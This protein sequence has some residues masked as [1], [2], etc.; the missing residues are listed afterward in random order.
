MTNL[1]LEIHFKQL[2]AEYRFSQLADEVSELINTT[3]WNKE[4]LDWRM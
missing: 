2:L 4:N 3:Q 1:E